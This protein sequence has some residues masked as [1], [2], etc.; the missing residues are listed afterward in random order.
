MSRRGRSSSDTANKEKAVLAGMLVVGLAIGGAAT[1]V[2][3]SGGGVSPQEAGEKVA[4]TLEDSTGNAYEVVDVEETSGMYRVRLSS[5]GNLQNYFVSLDGKLLSPT[6]TDLDQVRQTIDTRQQV[7][8]CLEGKEE[9]AL[10]GNLSQRPTRLQ[11]QVLGG[12]QSVSTYYKD[13]N[14]PANLQ[15]ATQRGV[16]SVPSL[17]VDGE[18]L[19]DVNN[20]SAISDFAG[21]GN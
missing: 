11:I 10:Y 9:A 18:T 1:F 15:E 20:L 6:M 2:G 7:N 16:S 5:N 4:S 14:N 3:T 12:A 19:G 21:C 13:V 17:Y 8:T